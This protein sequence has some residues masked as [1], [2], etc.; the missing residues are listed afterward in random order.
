MHILGS[1]LRRHYAKFIMLFIGVLVPLYLFGSLAEDVVEHEVFFFD[2]PILLFA[3]SQASP[4][5]DAVMY[6]FTRAG[7]SF[8]LAPFDIA[9]FFVLMWRR[10][11]TA[12][13]F[14]VLAVAGAALLNL[15]AKQ[16][17]A[18]T[19]PDLWISVLPETT[20]SFPSGHAMQS[21]AVVAAFTLLVWRTRWKWVTMA[22]GALFVAMVGLSRVY[23]GVHYPS[24][25][26]AGW[27]AALA[28]V[29]GLHILF[30]GRLERAKYR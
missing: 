16:A 17:F 15:L 9:V 19:R 6:V 7:S 12:A 28:W 11:R 24:D 14:W 5:L 20:Y 13:A 22:L 3:Y 18:R 10:H 1:W 29:L 4:W 30:K 2:R 27:V 8:V 26:L 25:I 23:W 21:M